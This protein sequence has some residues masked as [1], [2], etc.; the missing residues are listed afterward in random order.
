[1]TQAAAVVVALLSALIVPAPT[2]AAAS[3]DAQCLGSFTRTFA[4]PITQT[5]QTITVTETS[6]YSTCVVGPTA[7]GT[8]TATL[9]LSCVPVTPGPAITETLTWNDATGG[10]STINWSAP[11]IVAQTVVFTGTVTAG[12]HTGD[13]AT[14]ITSGTSYLGSVIGCLLGTPITST[15]GLI[16]SLLLTH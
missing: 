3:I 2:A 6:D 1:M 11:T 12:R 14:K 9:T 10:T 4:P 16:D 7:T 8:E 13:T 5:P 15:T